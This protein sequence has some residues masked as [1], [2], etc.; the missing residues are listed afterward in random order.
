MLPAPFELERYFARYE[1]RVR[2]LLS[3]S[4]CQCLSLAEL[5]ALADEPCRAWWNGLELHYTQSQGHPLLRAE[6]ARLYQQV[7]ADDVVIAVPEEAIYLAMQTLVAPGDHV[8]VLSPAYQS[9]F[10]VARAA[11]CEVT[12]WEL[13]LDGDR[14]T[15]DFDALERALTPKTRLLVIN[16]PHNPTG[17]LPPMDE[18]ERLIELCRSRNLYLFSDE[19][20]QQLEPSPSVRL[21]ALC[22]VYERGISLS[23]VSK[24]LGLPGLRIGWL[25]TRERRLIEAWLTLKDYLTICASAPS[26]VLATIALRARETILERNRA[27]VAENLRHAESFFGARRDR[28]HWVPPRAGSVAFPAW[29]GKK[30]LAE[31]CQEALERG[32]LVVPGKFFGHDGAHFRVGLGRRDFPQAL[33]E[34]AAIVDVG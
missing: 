1:F 17:H 16:F 23:G 14:W 29:R 34:L 13:R 15:L 27:L 30:P 20:Y 22:D 31:L 10:E 24:S 11:G 7:S 26:E 2:R 3:A 8:I 4:D 19:M 28:F 32:L 33:A 12:P 18:L 9:L 5:V 21:P 6:V 25:V